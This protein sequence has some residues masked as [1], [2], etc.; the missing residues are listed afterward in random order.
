M[1]PTY[2]P[3]I[4]IK[5]RWD[6]NDKKEEDYEKL[7]DDLNNPTHMEVYDPTRPPRFQTVKRGKR[8]CIH[9]KKEIKEGESSME[10]RDTGK[11]MCPK[12]EE[13]WFRDAAESGGQS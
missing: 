2:R 6:D 10:E 1:N 7:Q 4:I 12:C 8:T 3:D 11:H 9:C 13:K 5:G